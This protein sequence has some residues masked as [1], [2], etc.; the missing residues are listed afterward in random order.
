MLSTTIVFCH[1]TVVHV[2]FPRQNFKVQASIGHLLEHTYN[3][4]R[5]LSRGMEPDSLKELKQRFVLRFPKVIE[6]SPCALRACH[7][8][9]WGVVAC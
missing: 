6:H 8:P 4:T 2:L 3:S 7:H 9:G 5:G 1:Y